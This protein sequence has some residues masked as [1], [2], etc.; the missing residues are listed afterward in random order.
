MG[1]A[2]DFSR[3]EKRMLWRD[4][5]SVANK[6]GW[7]AE[8]V[9]DRF[10]SGP[11]ARVCAETTEAFYAELAAWEEYLSAI[12]KRNGKQMYQELYRYQWYE[13]WGRRGFWGNIE[14]AIKNVSLGEA[15]KIAI[16]SAGVGRDIVKVGLSAGI[17]KSSA[18]KG[19]RGTY[20]EISDFQKYFSLAKPNARIIVT[21]YNGHNLKSLK[22][23][24]SQM[25]KAGL[26]TEEMITVRC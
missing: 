16:L 18:P 26:L 1:E 19:I 9:Y 5:Q 13:G 22:E 21:E 24:V 3:F 10:S 15:P 17:W 6:A 20:K 8:D 4:V 14:D 2:V 12:G 23:M 11:E 25:I 7:I